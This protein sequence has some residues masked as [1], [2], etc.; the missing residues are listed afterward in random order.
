[1]NMSGVK[2][3][4]VI[5]EIEGRSRPPFFKPRSRRAWDM[6]AAVIQDRLMVKVTIK[7][8]G[9]QKRKGSKKR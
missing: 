8:V 2:V 4:P 5:V 9:L 7:P 3:K 1:M 6:M